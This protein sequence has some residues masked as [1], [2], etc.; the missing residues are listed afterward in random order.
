M[1]GK[2][3]RGKFFVSGQASGKLVKSERAISFWGGLDPATGEVIDRRSDVTGRS[4]AGKV[5]AFPEGI[6]SSTTSAVLLEAVRNGTNPVAVINIK[7][8]PILVTG[9]LVA[10]EIYQVD[11]PVVSL[12]REEYE[13]LDDG[14][15]IKLDGDSGLVS[16]EKR[17]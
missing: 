3:F 14:D 10:K 15:E 5:F 4:V 12:V 1:R 7:T 8:E 2:E 13:E 6:G 17:I 9:A 16:A 11:I